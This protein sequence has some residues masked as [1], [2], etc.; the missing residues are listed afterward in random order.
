MRAC[1]FR[2][3]PIVAR[4]SGDAVAVNRQLGS[5][6]SQSYARTEPALYFS[7]TWVPASH[8]VT[9]FRCALLRRISVVDAGGSCAH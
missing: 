6:T 7:D 1:S 2:A 5:S 4:W 3:A 8:F 9:G